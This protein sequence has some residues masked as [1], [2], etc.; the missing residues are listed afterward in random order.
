MNF[1]DKS[2]FKQNLK[3]KD[4]ALRFSFYFFRKPI[5]KLIVFFIDFS[6]Y[7]K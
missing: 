6:H 4:D 3:K 2:S 1:E 5:R 7:I